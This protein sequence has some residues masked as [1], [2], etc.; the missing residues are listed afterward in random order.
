METI[1]SKEQRANEIISKFEEKY[2]LSEKTM[3]VYKIIIRQLV[4]NKNTTPGSKAKFNQMN[5]VIK[6]LNKLGYDEFEVIEKGSKL[7]ENRIFKTNNKVDQT[8]DHYKEIQSMLPKTPKGRQLAFAMDLAVNAGLRLS[9]T[10][11]LERKKFIQKPNYIEITLN[12]ETK[13]GKYRIAYLPKD[14]A[15]ELKSFDG[16]DIDTTYV[17]TTL[18]RICKKLGVKFSFHSL[19]H[20]YA[21][22]EFDN[23][24]SITDLQHLLG[25]SDIST[26]SIYVEMSNARM[27]K[28][29]GEPTRK[30]A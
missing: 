11:S 19:R 22:T 10:I 4:D 29:V 3:R 30:F 17:Q 21:T 8:N 12:K 5:S 26:T 28:V 6:K 14:F 15:K 27:D 2:N 16:F 13:Y 20:T 23:G 9:E 1:K 18:N 25:H 7:D 24:K